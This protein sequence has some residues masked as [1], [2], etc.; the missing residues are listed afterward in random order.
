MKKIIVIS[1]LLLLTASF[2]FGQNFYGMGNNSRGMGNLQGGQNYLNCPAFG[3]G[4]L[5]EIVELSGQIT[6][7]ENSF[8][9]LK[10][11]KEET[12]ILVA[13]QAVESLGLKTGDTIS[14][15][16]FKVPGPTWDIDEKTAVRVQEI[17]VKGK[18]YLTG[19]FGRMG[20]GP[21]ERPF[22]QGK[23]SR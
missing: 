11:G 10:S 9:A 18:T 14:I 6:V 15:K 1:M 20:G 16:G 2:T 21:G 22:R 4:G 19:G 17:N 5:V 7:K 13:P 3:D 8:P 12:V 23:N